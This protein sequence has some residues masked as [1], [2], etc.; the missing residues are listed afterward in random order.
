VSEKCDFCKQELTGE[1]LEFAKDPAAHPGVL[2]LVCPKCYNKSCEA[3]PAE[4]WTDP[5]SGEV[6]WEQME[7]DLGCSPM[8]DECGED[9]Y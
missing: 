7:E 4:P 5:I 6:D 9:Y 1:D 2:S 3:D 8:G